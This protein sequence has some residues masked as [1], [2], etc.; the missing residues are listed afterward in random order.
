MPVTYST[1]SQTAV[2]YKTP[3]KGKISGPFLVLKIYMKFVLYA[4]TFH[5][6]YC[7]IISRCI[8]MIY[9]NDCSFYTF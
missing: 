9:T 2:H 4:A 7:I 6:Y 1:A 3:H 8:V 5:Y